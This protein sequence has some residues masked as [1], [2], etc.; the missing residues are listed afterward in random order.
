MKTAS[1][2]HHSL[3][4]HIAAM[5]ST[6]KW[7]LYKLG[8]FVGR[9]VTWCGV[10]RVMHEASFRVEIY[11]DVTMQGTIAVTTQQH[12]PCS[13]SSHYVARSL[14]RQSNK[15][16]RWFI[17]VCKTR[18]EL[19]WTLHAFNHYYCIWA[20]HHRS[21]HGRLKTHERITDLK[22]RTYFY[23]SCCCLLLFSFI[24]DV[25]VTVFLTPSLPADK[26]Y[27]LFFELAVQRIKIFLHKLLIY[28]EFKIQQWT[29]I[30]IS[31]FQLKYRQTFKHNM[32]WQH[33]SQ[34]SS[35]NAIC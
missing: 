7:P 31:Y 15:T 25:R 9:L 6:T 32:L 8:S 14:A 19:L 26:F 24:F 27:G 17:E 2:W 21:M 23:Y 18:L 30:L 33:S 13:L 11:T 16:T 28:N 1:R 22:K 4:T 12:N 20:W 29:I 10:L 34:F 5:C 3:T 35:K